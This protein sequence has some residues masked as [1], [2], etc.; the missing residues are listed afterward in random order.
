MADI[1]QAIVPI[2][3]TRIPA[4]KRDVSKRGTRRGQH[5]SLLTLLVFCRLVI[6]RI[7]NRPVRICAAGSPVKRSVVIREEKWIRLVPGG[8]NA[9][10]P[11]CGSVE[12]PRQA[13]KE[14]LIRT[15]RRGKEAAVA[16]TRLSARVSPSS[17]SSATRGAQFA[18]TSYRSATIPRN[19]ARTISAT[20]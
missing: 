11:P 9:V 2:I 20:P 15:K 14:T 12:P 7:W 16:D 3:D 4:G 8:K 6:E 17:F 5:S 13:L 1:S 18:F 10:G 19:C